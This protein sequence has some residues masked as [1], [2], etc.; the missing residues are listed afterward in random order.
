[1][2]DEVLAAGRGGKLKAA[3]KWGVGVDNVDFESAKNHNIP[4]KNT[5]GVFNDEVADLAIGYMISLARQTHFIDREVR[6]GNWPKPTGTSLKGKTLAIFGFGNIGSEIAKRAL[7]F[8]MKVIGYDPYI[9]NDRLHGVNMKTWPESL[10]EADFIIIAASLNDGNKRIIN[11]QTIELMK[12]GVRLINVSR[13]GLIKESDLV[14][15]LRFGRID[16]VALDVFEEEPPIYTNDLFCNSRSIFGSHN[17]SNTSEAVL[18]TSK[19]SIK[20]L[21][22]LINENSQSNG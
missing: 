16:S 17:A 22:S 6:L 18:M 21:R 19:L 2:T 1:V 14:E 20:I 13:G 11:K 12:K 5:P 4:I 10:G 15:A 9:E 8:G 3:V 7:V